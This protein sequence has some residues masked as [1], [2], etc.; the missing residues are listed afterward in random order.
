MK[1]NNTDNAIQI[2]NGNIIQT[3][4]ENKLEENPYKNES[5]M[6]KPN[7]KVKVKVNDNKIEEEVDDGETYD[8]YN[9]L[10]KLPNNLKNIPNANDIVNNSNNN[11][12][13]NYDNLINNNNNK[14]NNDSKPNLD[15]PRDII[16]PNNNDQN[17]INN[18]SLKNLV[19]RNINNVNNNIPNKVDDKEINHDIEY[20]QN[21]DSNIIENPQD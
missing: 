17:N 16:N 2:V 11:I 3:S 4:K 1:N 18:T 7:E 6:Y 21:K 13:N 15:K 9:P 5:T 12:P 19:D 8:S 20:N 14:P 10:D